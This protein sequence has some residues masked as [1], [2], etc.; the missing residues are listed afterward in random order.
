MVTAERKES[1][2]FLCSLEIKGNRFKLTGEIG[3]HEEKPQTD[4]KAEHR[5]RQ[6][7]DTAISPL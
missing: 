2:S 6:F 4:G 1:N 5:Q 3:Q 7:S